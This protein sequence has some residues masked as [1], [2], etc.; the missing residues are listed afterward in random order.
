MCMFIVANPVPQ[1]AMRDDIV[2]RIRIH[3]CSGVPLSRYHVGRYALG[4]WAWLHGVT[5]NKQ[6]N[7]TQVYAR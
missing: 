4:C 2:R 7:R 3:H 6:V 1:S 5:R